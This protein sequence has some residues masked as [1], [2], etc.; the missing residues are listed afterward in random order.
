MTWSANNDLGFGLVS[1]PSGTTSAFAELG[2]IKK[3]GVLLVS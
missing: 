1:E 3:W 2:Q